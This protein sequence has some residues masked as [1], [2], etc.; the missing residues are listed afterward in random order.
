MQI[1]LEIPVEPERLAEWC[2]NIDGACPLGPFA[3]CPLGPLVRCPLRPPEA[4]RRLP[5]CDAGDMAGR[6]ALPEEK[7]CE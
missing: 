7:P 6:L 4:A 3:R 1:K 2:R 5:D